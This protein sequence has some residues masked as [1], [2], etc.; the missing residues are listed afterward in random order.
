MSLPSP[1]RILSTLTGSCSFTLRKMNYMSDAR[2]WFKLNWSPISPNCKSLW[3]KMRRLWLLRSPS[4][5]TIREWRW[6]MIKAMSGYFTWKLMGNSWTINGLKRFQFLRSLKTSKLLPSW[7]RMLKSRLSMRPGIW[8]W[9]V[10]IVLDVGLM[11]SLKP[12]G[13]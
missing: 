8:Q 3:K 7:W 2:M 13:I 10:W 5:R 6:P 11:I 12:S 1:I 9:E 4:P